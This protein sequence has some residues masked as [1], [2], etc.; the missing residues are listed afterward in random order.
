MCNLFFFRPTYA[1]GK[2]LQKCGLSVNDI[3]VFEIHEAFAVSYK[4]SAREQR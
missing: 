2:L 1:T 3:D 4:Y